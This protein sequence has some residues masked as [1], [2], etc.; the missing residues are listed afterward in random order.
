MEAYGDSMENE[1]IGIGSGENQLR[2]DLAEA[3][4]ET[5]AAP[6]RVPGK[7]ENLFTFMQY[8]PQTFSQIR[9]IIYSYNL[10]KNYISHSPSFIKRTLLQILNKFS[11]YIFLSNFSS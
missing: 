3:M 1:N 7:L 10:K 5:S 8:Y 4:L 6:H 2:E 11:N 9:N